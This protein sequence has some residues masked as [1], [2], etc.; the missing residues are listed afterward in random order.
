M[1]SL[2]PSARPDVAAADARVWQ[3]R[4]TFFRIRYSGYYKVRTQYF[5][6]ADATGN[7]SGSDVLDSELHYVTYGWSVSA[8][9][10]CRY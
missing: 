5:W 4:T 1:A 9:K 8:D 6:Y 7:K 10:W 3:S 2:T